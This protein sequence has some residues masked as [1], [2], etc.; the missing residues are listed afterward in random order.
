MK[1]EST[2]RNIIAQ[3]DLT[4]IAARVKKENRWGLKRLKAAENA[5]RGF[6]F[7]CW[8]YPK[9]KA[10]P[11]LDIDEFWHAHILYTRK[12]FRDCNKIYGRYAHH[13][14]T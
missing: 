9:L 10:V 12:Y 3:L 5:Y 2:V 1:K 11:S 4:A 8:K 6:L 14:P 7:V 13:N